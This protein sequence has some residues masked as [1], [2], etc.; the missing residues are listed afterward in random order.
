MPSPPEVNSP[1]SNH[2]IGLVK[3]SWSKLAKKSAKVS[4]SFYQR[5]F[6]LDEGMISVFEDTDMEAQGKKFADTITFIVKGLDQFELLGP[7]I[8]ELGKR[9]INYGVKNDHYSVVKIALLDT[10]ESES[11]SGF[12]EDTSCAWEATYNALADI[13]R[14]GSTNKPLTS[15][16]L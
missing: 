1:L 10:L 16:G 4:E 9:H 7:A 3:E 14:K 6:E 8:G 11:S 5:L 12:S 15:P 13:M 2:Q